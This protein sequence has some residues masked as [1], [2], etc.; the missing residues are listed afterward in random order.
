MEKLVLVIGKLV[1]IHLQPMFLLVQAE[2]TVENSSSG[3]GSST[4]LLS[5]VRGQFPQLCQAVLL[6]AAYKKSW[7][8]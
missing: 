8:D 5:Q 2:Q 1:L 3:T 6:T 4:T 7:R